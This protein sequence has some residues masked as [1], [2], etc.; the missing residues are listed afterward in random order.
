MD[1]ERKTEK[2]HKNPGSY[3]D[4]ETLDVFYTYLKAYLWSIRSLGVIRRSKRDMVGRVSQVDV[5]VLSLRSAN[6][7]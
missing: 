3:H 2:R 7:I 1:H 5:T 6:K 4:K